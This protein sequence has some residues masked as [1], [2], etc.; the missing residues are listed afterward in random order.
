L[1]LGFGEKRSLF[2]GIPTHI[3][4]ISSHIKTTNNSPWLTPFPVVPNRISVRSDRFFSG[5]PTQIFAISNHIKTTISVGAT[6]RGCP[7]PRGS[8]S[9]FVNERSRFG[10]WLKGDRMFDFGIGGK[11]IARLGNG[12]IACLILGLREKRSFG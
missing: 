9:D 5:I 1:V 6:P 10:K 12:A 8:Q 2:S 3:F 7:L 11:A 4:A